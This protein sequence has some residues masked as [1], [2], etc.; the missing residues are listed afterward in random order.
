MP[1]PN[2]PLYNPHGLGKPVHKSAPKPPPPKTPVTFPS[3]T[4][5]LLGN[6]GTAN[7]AFGTRT[8]LNVKGLQQQLVKAGY[9]IKVDGVLGA[10]TLSAARDYYGKPHE[11]LAQFKTQLTDPSF[12]AKGGGVGDPQGWDH[13]HVNVTAPYATAQVGAGGQPAPGM[14]TD[15][16]SAGGTIDLG[17]TQAALPEGKLVPLGYAKFGTM[18]DPKTA[19]DIAGAQFDPQIAAEQLAVNEDPLQAAQNLKDIT[20]WYGQVGK[21]QQLAATH[22]HAMT[23]A[24]TGSIGDAAA[25]LLSSVGGSANQGAHDVADAGQN[26]QGT[27]AAIGA[28]TDQF[29]QEIA[30]LLA[31]EGAGQKVN[32]SR[33]DAKQ[34]LADRTQLTS[35]Q[36][37]KGQAAQ[38]ALA[39]IEGENNTLAQARAQMADQILG[40]N[41]A[42]RQQG[43][44]NRMSLTNAQIAAEM[45]GLKLANDQAK[46][47]K[48]SNPNGFMFWSP[49]ARSNA[50]ATAIQTLQGASKRGIKV[51]PQMARQIIASVY[52]GQGVDPN[53]PAVRQAMNGVF[54]T[55]SAMS[56]GV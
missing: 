3:P 44:A 34:L 4:Q 32:Q 19:Q 37:A 33:L 16:A 14:R 23:A 17:P 5:R 42:T 2:K 43:F 15:G 8:P 39:Q 24:G 40:Q 25:A 27:V 36:S 35:L 53:S 45:S 7:N 30:P 28:A 18:I 55:W 54:N 56:G 10:E 46:L 41:N 49:S 48:A 6:K 50:Q 29:N 26:A 22:E 31:A 51:T 52:Q 13:T 21:A 1:G 11:P 12:A 20:S 38:A 47:G 9:K